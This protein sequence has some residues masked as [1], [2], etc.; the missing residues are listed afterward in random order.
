MVGDWPKTGLIPEWLEDA[1][2]PP[3]GVQSVDSLKGAGNFSFPQ[4]WGETSPQVATFT[5]GEP[6]YK[7]KLG[8]DLI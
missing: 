4:V 8:C 1:S 7:L 5:G 2:N 6:Q 3:W